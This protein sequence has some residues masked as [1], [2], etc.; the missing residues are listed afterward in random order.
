MIPVGEAAARLGVGK[1]ALSR[2]VDLGYLAP[3]ATP[4]GHRRFRVADVDVLIEQ[5]PKEA[6]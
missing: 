2:L 6:R 3:R 5:A 1:H 4:S